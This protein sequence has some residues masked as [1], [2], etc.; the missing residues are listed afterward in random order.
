[1]TNVTVLRT[2]FFNDNLAECL[3]RKMERARENQR[4]FWEDEIRKAEKRRRKV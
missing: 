2:K 4:A 1:M 3:C